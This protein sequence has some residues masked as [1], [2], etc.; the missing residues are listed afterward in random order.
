VPTLLLQD[1]LRAADAMHFDDDLAGIK[2]RYPSATFAKQSDLKSKGE[3]VFI[4]LNGEAPYKIDKTWET[5]A[6]NKVIKVAYPEFVVKP[7]QIAYATVSVSGASAKTEMMEDVNA[8]ALQ[9]LKDRMGR[10]K[11]KMV[12]RAIAKFVAAKAAEVVAS[13]AGG[14]A[15]G[16][17]LGAAASVA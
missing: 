9:S 3:I 15:L 4:H 10:V 14:G 8:I 12:A 17:L 5:I 6:D 16:S 7:K 2:K 11:A 13:K 1:A